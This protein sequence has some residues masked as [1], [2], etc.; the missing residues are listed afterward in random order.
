M[1]KPR[2]P[3]KTGADIKLFLGL[4]YEY[5][6]FMHI[7]PPRNCPEYEQMTVVEITTRIKHDTEELLARAYPS[8]GKEWANKFGS[9]WCR[10]IAHL[11]PRGFCPPISEGYGERFA[12]NL[13]KGLWQDL[14]SPEDSTRQKA[15]EEFH[16]LL[17]PFTEKESR[18]AA[19]ALAYLAID[20]AR[21]ME[22]LSVKR[23]EVIQEVAKNHDLWPVN[24]GVRKRVSRNG[25]KG[26]L[27]HVITRLDF[28]KEYLNR[29]GVGSNCK[30]PSTESTGAKPQSLF[31]LAAQ[32]LLVDLL[33]MKSDPSFF[34]KK[35]TPWM[36]KLVA[37]PEPMT[38][39]HVGKWWAV[40]K[41]LVD[42]QWKANPRFFA[43]LIKSCG[44][45]QQDIRG[46]RRVPITDARR[47]SSEKKSKVIDQRLKE[48]FET[49]A[50]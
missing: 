37:L 28:A 11:D 18:D 50:T 42:E 31:R 15:H 41:Q 35:K 5:Q 46:K 47:G 19:N 8:Y 32:R 25:G 23:A 10:G 1:K 36:R 27:T 12:E 6:G 7:Q 13:R 44:T 3:S 40:A 33:L 49:L 39:A 9:K 26:Q 29:L 2:N 30:L 22:N 43:P 48:A 45:W 4:D 34:F 21:W 16:Y 17:K 38:K 20:A 24:L 14:H